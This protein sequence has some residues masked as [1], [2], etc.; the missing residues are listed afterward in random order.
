MK[1]VIF[2]ENPNTMLK[3]LKILFFFI[4]MLTHFSL[5]ANGEKKIHD[6]QLERFIT[7]D[8]LSMLYLAEDH[9]DDY[10]NIYFEMLDLSAKLTAYPEITLNFHKKRGQFFHGI[11]LYKE[12]LKNNKKAISCLENLDP[13]SLKKHYALTTR[14]LGNNAAIYTSLGHTDSTY[15]QF[16]KAIAHV[17]YNYNYWPIS[18]PS[19]INNMGYYFQHY[20]NMT[21]SALFYYYMSDSII[22]TDF[23]DKELLLGSVRDNIATVYVENKRYVEA[24]ELFAKNFD[25]YNIDSIPEGS[26]E[27]ERW[28]RAGS[29]WAEMEIELNNQSK[30]KAI[31][32]SVEQILQIHHIYFNKKAKARYLLAL[33]KYHLKANNYKD[34]YEV[35][36]QYEKLTDSIANR[37]ITTERKWD[38]KMNHIA[39]NRSQRNY[40]TKRQQNDENRRSERIQLW[41]VISIL[42]LG[43]L[44]LYY[45]YKQNLKDVQQKKLIS[46]QDLRL[47]NLENEI[48]HQNIELKK[49]DLSDFALNYVQDIE[50]AH[51]LSEKLILYKKSR[52]NQRTATLKEFEKEIEN[53]IKLK[54]NNPELYEKVDLLSNEFY[55]KLS[56]ECPT[57][58]KS[59]IRLCS[60]IRLK[61]ESSH[62]SQLLNISQTSLHQARYRLRKKLGLSAQDNLNDYCCNL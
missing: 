53:K 56:N 44:S 57:L 38:E 22:R 43:I 28:A 26:Y 41:I 13:I 40:L 37:K 16:K 19:T 14:L 51:V 25:F 59:E 49:R 24:K 61:L 8:S 33:N 9:I 62:I 11:G 29:Q 27:C 5:R 36:S 45:F 54:E 31:L 4:V 7:L 48:L 21:D 10:L 15:L 1:I 17:K 60:L 42:C 18:H 52:G 2:N 50:W 47:K 30:A 55:Q 20:T 3:P 46:D 6:Q 39:F 35:L 58:T 23:N 34:A 12:A 32:D